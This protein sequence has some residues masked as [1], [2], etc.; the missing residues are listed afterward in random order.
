MSCEA[1]ENLSSASSELSDPPSDIDRQSWPSSPATTPPRPKRIS[2]KPLNPSN[3]SPKPK[4]QTRRCSSPKNSSPKPKRKT[5]RSTKP[6]RITKKK[7]KKC[8]KSKSKS[9]SKYKLAVPFFPIAPDQ[10]ATTIANTKVRI[11]GEVSTAQKIWEKRHRGQNYPKEDFKDMELKILRESVKY[12]G[13]KA[14]EAEEEVEKLKGL[15]KGNDELSAKR[16]KTIAEL[17]KRLG[18]ARKHSKS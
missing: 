8:S 10:I 9:K 14:R 5:G 4:R 15:G 13:K 2:R 18:M 1:N 11:F 17:K 7:G 6:T 16:E 3:L 12:W